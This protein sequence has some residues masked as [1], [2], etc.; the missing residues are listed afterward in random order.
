MSRSRVIS[1]LLALSALAVIG[2]PLALGLGSAT[3]GS[4]L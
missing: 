4:G 2:A 1:G 3:G